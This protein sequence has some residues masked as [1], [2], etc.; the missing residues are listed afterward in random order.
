MA[1]IRRAPLAG[2]R[3]PRALVDSRSF[4]MASG[5]HMM[6]TGSEVDY[7]SFVL[8]SYIPRRLERHNRPPIEVGRMI[9]NGLDR[10]PGLG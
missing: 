2:I 10:I 9:P 7:N 3:E 8:R 4:T 5:L 1:R 6:W